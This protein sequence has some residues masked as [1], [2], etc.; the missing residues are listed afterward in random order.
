MT[1]R[2]EPGECEACF[3]SP[4]DQKSDFEDLLPNHFSGVTTIE[5]LCTFLRNQVI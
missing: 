1:G 4:A 2:P 5:Q 3:D